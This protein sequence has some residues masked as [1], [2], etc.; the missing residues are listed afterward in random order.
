[1]ILEKRLATI[2]G[3]MGITPTLHH[4]V[5]LLGYEVY[6]VA[7]LLPHTV[8]E[9]LIQEYHEYV[10]THGFQ[11]LLG[12]QMD[13]AM[14]LA[15]KE[16][17]LLFEEVYKLFELYDEIEAHRELGFAIDDFKYSQFEAGLRS[18]ASNNSEIAQLVAQ[19]LFKDWKGGWWLYVQDL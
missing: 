10:K 14:S 8:A 19:R 17:Q 11:D 18:W 6:C 5:A 3:K 13:Y 15:R 4:Q 2:R 16:D 12:H 1:M 7:K 9:A